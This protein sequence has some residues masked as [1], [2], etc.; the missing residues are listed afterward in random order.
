[1]NF[2]RLALSAFFISAGV[3]HFIWAASYL[4]IMPPYVP[5]PMAMI[6][7]TGIAEV[8]G[9]VGVAF[10][11]TRKAAGIG[12]IAFLLAVF[13]ANIQAALHGMTLAGGPV[14]AWLLWLRLPMQP[15][16]IAW[17]YIACWRER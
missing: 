1:M 8:S 10:A 13:P 11:R 14:P 6:Y 12:L 3:S 17:V 4:Q 2:S 9:G 5:A 7:F 16:L 15:L